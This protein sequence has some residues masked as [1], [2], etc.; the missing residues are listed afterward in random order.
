M[1][2]NAW[3]SQDWSSTRWLVLGSVGGLASYFVLR[4]NKKQIVFVGSAS[5]VGYLY[6]SRK[7]PPRSVIV[8][9]PNGEERI[10]GLAPRQV[11]QAQ[12]VIEAISRITG[13]EAEEWL[14]VGTVCITMS[15]SL[16]SKKAFD[17]WYLAHM[18]K[19]YRGL[20]DRQ[21]DLYQAGLVAHGTIQTWNRLTG[22]VPIVG[23][24]FKLKY[25]RI[26]CRV[27]FVAALAIKAAEL[28]KEQSTQPVQQ[29]DPDGVWEN[30]QY[31]CGKIVNKGGDLLVSAERGVLM[32]AILKTIHGEDKDLCYHAER[33]LL[34][35][36]YIV[37]K[38]GSEY[39]EKA[40]E[41]GIE[42]IMEAEQEEDGLAMGAI[43]PFV[44]QAQAAI[45]AQ[46]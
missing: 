37:G 40:I 17:S 45:G 8:N 20:S 44:Q 9:G 22:T 18:L 13:H 11:H 5:S 38:A 43:W 21:A 27:L 28:A 19:E 2:I 7:R 33:T 35:N 46:L 12:R 10:E 34:F 41:F 42:Y 14:E 36:A 23:R 30:I 6:G 15:A 25:P 26:V 32:A 31:H 4:P 3:T 16:S 29:G 1:D 24:Q 39:L